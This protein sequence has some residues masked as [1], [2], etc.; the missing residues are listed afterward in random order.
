V[1]VLCNYLWLFVY[2]FYSLWRNSLHIWV[3]ASQDMKECER[4]CWICWI[5]I[6]ALYTSNTTYQKIIIKTSLTYPCIS[7][8]SIDIQKRYLL[9]YPCYYPIK[10]PC[11]IY[12]FHT[13]T[14]KISR[15]IF[16]HIPLYPFIFLCIHRYPCLS[17]I[18]WCRLSY[19]G[20][21]MAIIIIPNYWKWVAKIF[22]FDYCINY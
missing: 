13:M 15:Y 9:N 20:L 7:F 17:N 6:K 8:L 10:V 12:M 18:F 4:I 2:Y 21:S 1:I 19:P 3:L 14:P 11:Q 5:W 22:V 16:T